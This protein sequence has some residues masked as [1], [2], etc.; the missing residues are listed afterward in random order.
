VRVVRSTSA[1]PAPGT[2]LSPAEL[3]AL[4]TMLPRGRPVDLLA[5]GPRWYVPVTLDGGEGVTSPVVGHPGFPPVADVT[6]TDGADHL[7]VR[8]AWPEGCTESQVSWRGPGGAG[9]AK[10]TNMKY[11]IDGGF[12][13][14]VAAP[15]A[16][17]IAVAPGA[18]LGRDLVWSAPRDTISHERG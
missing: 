6:V 7:L 14:P 1:P 16:Y 8:W 13:L 9:Q 5:G 11:Q 4:G 17:E 12:R 3:D 10:V 2:R 18:R 15:G